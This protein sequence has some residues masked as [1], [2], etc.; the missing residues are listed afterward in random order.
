M[1]SEFAQWIE[2]DDD[3]QLD[4]ALT[5]VERHQGI[6]KLIT[7]LNTLYKNETALHYWDFSHDG[8][9]WIDCNDSDQ[10]VLSLLRKSKNPHESIVCLLN[11]TPVPRNNYRIGVPAAD[12]Y[13]EILNTDS[14]Y[15]AG[16]NCGNQNPVKID[17]KPWSGF[18]QSICLTLPPLSA[19]FLKG[20]YST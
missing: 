15:Y 1:G 9:E 14:A 6:S 16:S 18:E 4:W 10:S 20:N 3:G 19:V 17:A 7:D 12:N 2:W 8:F 5:S 11:F 13:H